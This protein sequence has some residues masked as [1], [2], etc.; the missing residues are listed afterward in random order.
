MTEIKSILQKIPFSTWQTE[1]D[2]L[3]EKY[4]ADNPDLIVEEAKAVFREV[5]CVCRS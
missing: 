4:E 1:I 5:H 2:R 3:L